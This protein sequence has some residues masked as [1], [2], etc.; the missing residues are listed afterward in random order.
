[1]P[2]T[3]GMHQ[4]ERRVRDVR[5]RAWNAMLIHKTFTSFQIQASSD[6][7]KSNLSK[8][9]KALA[10]AGYIKVQRPR[11]SG[12]TMGHTVWRLAR[13]TGPKC[14]IVRAD[15]SGVYDCNQDRLYPYAQ[16]GSDGR[17][18]QST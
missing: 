17:V 9:L 14:P 2:G 15:G 18:A 13:N 11:Q 7:G 6:I 4:K 10:R 12:R 5:Q 16:E 8:Y 3:S 1:M